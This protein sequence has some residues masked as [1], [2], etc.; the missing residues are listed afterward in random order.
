VITSFDYFNQGEFRVQTLIL[1]SVVEPSMSNV[2]NNTNSATH[3][4]NQRFI[5][6]TIELNNNTMW[7]ME[8][9]LLGVRERESESVC[10]CVCLKIKILLFHQL[11]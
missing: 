11:V 4:N 8:S 1:K 10:V 9:L 7:R 3:T 6:T 5:V 2:E